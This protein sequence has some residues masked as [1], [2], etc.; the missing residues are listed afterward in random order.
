MCYAAFLKKLPALCVK[1]RLAAKEDRL[2]DRRVL[3]REHPVKYS[4]KV[5]PELIQALVIHG[6]P[7]ALRAYFCLVK[8]EI[9]A[10]DPIIRL[11]V[12]S[13]R[14]ARLAKIR[15]LALHSDRAPGF[16]LDQIR[17]HT[18]VT[19]HIPPHRLLPVLPHARAPSLD[20]LQPD[21]QRFPLIT[22]LVFLFAH[23]PKQGDPL[24]FRAV[25]HHSRQRVAL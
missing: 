4:L 13:A 9:H 14:I 10:E 5:A 7:A 8:P 1:L 20:I 25:L 2:H 19:D 17:V 6:I 22:T 16:G 24:T 11:C 15:H 18:D 3:R 23:F 21:H 12:K